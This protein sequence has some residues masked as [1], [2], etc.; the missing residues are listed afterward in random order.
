MH[1][2]TVSHTAEDVPQVSLGKRKRGRETDPMCCGAMCGQALTYLMEKLVPSGVVGDAALYQSTSKE[3]SLVIES[4]GRWIMGR[5]N[6]ERGIH[7]PTHRYTCTLLY[8]LLRIIARRDVDEW[9]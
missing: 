4:L 1:A 9:I 3:Y 2:G 6:G 5:P 7:A 8:Q